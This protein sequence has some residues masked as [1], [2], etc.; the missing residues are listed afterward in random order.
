MA[1]GAAGPTGEPA[2]EVKGQEPEAATTL[3][4]EEGAGTA[5]GSKA[6][7]NPVKSQI[8]NT[9][10]KFSRY[11]KTLIAIKSRFHSLLY[12]CSFLPSG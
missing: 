7:K 3:P 10:S 4:L 8:Y 1:A 12:F 6:N 2:L 5:S 11:N 9:Y